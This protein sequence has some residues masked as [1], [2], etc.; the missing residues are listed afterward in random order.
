MNNFYRYLVRTAS[1]KETKCVYMIQVIYLKDNTTEDIKVFDNLG[2][3]I[4]DIFD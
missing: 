2:N 4:T 3:D 1:G